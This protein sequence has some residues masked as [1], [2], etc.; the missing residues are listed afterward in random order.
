MPIE[1]GDVVDSVTTTLSSV[2]A[3]LIAIVLLAGPTTVW[4]LYRFVVQPRTSRYRFAG[5]DPLWVC[6]NCRSANAINRS[7]CYR[8]GYEPAAH[9]SVEVVVDVDPMGADEILE[10]PGTGGGR[11]VGVPVG[12]GIAA[13]TGAASSEEREPV[14]VG[15]GPTPARPRA[16]RPRR[17]VV[18]GRG[19][20]AEPLE[21]E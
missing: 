5:S 16:A 18:A 12:P 7:R 17:A 20:A 4:L 10:L 9:E 19:A 11:D 21:E 15:P 6:D 2:P 14:A 3:A 13:R 1:L 8:C